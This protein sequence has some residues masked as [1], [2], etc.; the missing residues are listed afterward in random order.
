M[1]IF[2]N[3]GKKIDYNGVIHKIKQSG[4]SDNDEPYVELE[5]ENDELQ[6]RMIEAIRKKGA[7]TIIMGGRHQLEL[8]LD[9][10][11]YGNL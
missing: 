8:G 6:N 9:K 11:P 1:T 7:L 10:Y 2:A 3:S 4:I 5:P